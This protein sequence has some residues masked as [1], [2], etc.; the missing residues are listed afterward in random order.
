MP[1]IL[2]LLALFAALSACV[3][4]PEIRQGNF[5]S[6]DK[7]AQVKPGLT[8]AQVQ[9]ILGKVMVQDPFHPDRW[10]YV[11]YVNPNNGKPVENW[12]VVVYFKDGKVDHV[13]QLSAQNKDT[14]LELPKVTDK[15][16]AQDS[17]GGP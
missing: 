17:V 8:P 16:S 2:L 10:D 5:L 7:I 14:Q 15:P 9:F 13:Q 3:F 12:H 6:D 1:R 4:K 11:Q